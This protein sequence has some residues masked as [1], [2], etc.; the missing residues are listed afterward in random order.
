[1]QEK[2]TFFEMKKAKICFQDFFS[3]VSLLPE[4]SQVPIKRKNGA[5]CIF[6]V[7]AAAELIPL[8]N[9]DIVEMSWVP[10]IWYL[11]Q[12]II[13]PQAKPLTGVSAIIQIDFDCNNRNEDCFCSGLRW[14]AIGINI[15]TI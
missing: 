11:R 6:Q 15:G 4:A 5:F 2:E 13:L 10:F 9:P 8:I 14:A 3:I 1:M 7:D 12:S